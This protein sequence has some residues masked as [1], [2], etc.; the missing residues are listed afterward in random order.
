MKLLKQM[1]AATL[2]A[3]SGLGQ[4]GAGVLNFD[5]LPDWAGPVPTNYAGFTFNNW[6]YI[7]NL[8]NDWPFQ[9]PPN[10]IY[11]RGEP[12]VNAPDILFGGLHNVRSVY[13]A[14]FNLPGTVTLRGYSGATELYTV[15][16]ALDVGVMV[17]LTLDFMGIDRLVM[18]APSQQGFIF[19]DD[20]EVE[21]VP[22]PGSL[23]LFSI[24]L[25]AVHAWQTRRRRAACPSP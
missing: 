20:L 8:S 10:V 2:L 22:E 25:L 11:N 15:S 23:A 9:S 14:P 24:G 17:K 19:L 6:D 4:A 16:Q 18:E 7:D 21:A 1:A 12:Y 5:D 13:A 3:V